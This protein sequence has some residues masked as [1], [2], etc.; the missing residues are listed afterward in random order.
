M[1]K[2]NPAARARHAGAHSVGTLSL[3]IRER[4]WYGSLLEY[5]AKH[6]PTSAFRWVCA[7]VAV[8]SA[9][10]GLRRLP[11]YGFKAAEVYGAVC[12]LALTCCWGGRFP[13]IQKS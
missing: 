9:A 5:A 4:Y 2:Y 11:R 1:V 8:G 10:R 3:E 12:R 13:A 6:Y 7:A